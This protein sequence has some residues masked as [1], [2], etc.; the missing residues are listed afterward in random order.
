MQIRANGIRL[1]V[2]DHGSPQGER[3]FALWNPPLLDETTGA[4]ASANVETAS[5]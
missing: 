3:L 1:E 5:L 4:R 2:E